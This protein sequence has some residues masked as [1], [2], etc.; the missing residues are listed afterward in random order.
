MRLN[1]KWATWLA[2]GIV[3]WLFFTLGVFYWVQKPLSLANAV[4]LGRTVLELG[5]A[6]LIGVAG[7]AL[8]GRVLCWLRVDGVSAGDRLI[9]GTGLGLGGLGLTTFALGLGGV[10]SR[11]V[12]LIVLAGLVISF[13]REVL[14]VLSL[15]RA[16]WRQRPHWA[17]GALIGITL[18]LALLAAL[19][20]PT[21]WD[22]LFYHLTWPAWALDAGRIGPPPVAVPHFS[23]PG[24]MESLF[25]LAM[26]VLDDVAAKLV[27]WLFALLLG[28]L[29][30][31][32][33]KR[34]IGT[35]LGWGAV[36]ALYA[37]PMVGV[38]A[39][40]AYNDLALAF[41]QIAALYAVL[42]ARSQ[43]ECRWLALAGMF[44]GLA[45]GLKYTSVICPVVLTLLI[46]RDGMQQRCGWRQGLARVALFAGTALAVASPWYVRNWLFVGNPVYPF[47]YSVFGGAGWSRWLAE[48][49]AQAGTGMGGDVGQILALPVTLTLGLRDMN[50]YDGRTGPLFLAALPAVLAV[51]AFDRRKPRAVASLLWFALGQYVFW[52]VG[53]VGS[54]SLFQSRLLLSGLVALCPVLAYVFG[55]LRYLNR[56]GFS[57]QRFVGLAIVLVLAFGLLYQML[58][59]VRLRPV[60]YLTGK[61][62]REAFLTRR[63][64]AHYAAMQAVGDLPGDAVVQFLWEPRSYYGGR[65]V[66][67][68]PI[69]ETWAYLCYRHE[70]DVDGIA[71]ALR[72]E[73]GVTHIL[74]FVA[75]MEN[76]VQE[77]PEHLPPEDVAAWDSFRVTYLEPL[78]EM[79]G[80]YVLYTWH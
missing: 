47:A 18:G 14:E 37:T 68:D 12:L 6:G 27:H 29:V 79:P 22:G 16:M 48:W 41:F 40:W 1:R 23:F 15:R 7:L 69:L 67:P 46:A 58:D 30:Y 3:V 31:R 9:L 70:R 13:R 71:Q 39:G 25:L 51:A 56:P 38:L 44:A 20:P 4:A 24:L 17:V 21:D 57:V 61:E 80:V 10:L 72:D 33:T 26:A 73:L 36:V 8:G 19:T 65:V 35:E 45:M 66:Q 5:V 77:T 63:L 49:Y 34:H 50:Y 2:I 64:G 75:G 52:V 53:V 54:R 76:V 62:T 42:T 59:V 60:D 43:S 78:W 32:L 74:V 28:G 11:W 55:A